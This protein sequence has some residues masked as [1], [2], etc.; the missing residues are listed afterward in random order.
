MAEKFRSFLKVLRIEINRRLLNNAVTRINSTTEKAQGTLT[1]IQNA[2]AAKYDVFAKQIRKDISSIQKNVSQLEPR[3]L[4]ERVVKW[5]QWYQQLTGLD[6]VEL[7]RRQVI[8]AQ[9]KLFKS[10]DERRLLNREVAL[11]NDKLKE[12]YSE[13]IQTKRDDPKYVQLTILENKSLQDQAR[14]MS[15]LNLLDREE[16]DHFTQLATAI[17]EYHDSQTMSAQKYKY[18]SILASAVV[19]IISL[20]GSMIYNNRKIAMIKN[21]MHSLETGLNARFSE[22]LTK[23]ENNGEQD[24]PSE[25]NNPSRYSYSYKQIGLGILGLYTVIKALFYNSSP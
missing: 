17:K 1:N 19:A 2:V 11:I 3:P 18:L 14:I 20:T 12:V 23:L 5:W 6:I 22:V 25:T 21:S 15:H 24:T 13:L 16:R 10:Q 9:D 7:S 4:P 8:L